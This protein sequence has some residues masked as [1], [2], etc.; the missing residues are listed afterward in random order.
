M[1]SF[2]EFYKIVSEDM[3]AGGTGS[4]FGPTAGDGDIKTG[5]TQHDDSRMPVLLQQTPSRKKKKRKKTRILSKEDF[6][7][8]TKG[9]VKISNNNK[10]MISLSSVQ[11]R[12]KIERLAV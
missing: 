9:P 11:K 7:A 6:I 4:A 1:I 10:P 2:T 12:P 5:I 8:T 3:S